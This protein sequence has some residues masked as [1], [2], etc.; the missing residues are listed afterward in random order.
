MAEMKNDKF[1]MKNWKTRREI[2]LVDRVNVLLI[3]TFFIFNF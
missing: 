1:K 2:K 3:F